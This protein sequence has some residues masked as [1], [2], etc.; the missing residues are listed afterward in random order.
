LGGG[1]GGGFKTQDFFS[2]SSVWQINVRTLQKFYRR[3]E[4]WMIFFYKQNDK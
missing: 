2:E 4:P 1:G 3:T